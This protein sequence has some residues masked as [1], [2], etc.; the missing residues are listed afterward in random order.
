MIDLFFLGLKVFNDIY[1]KYIGFFIICATGIYF[2]IK[3]K[4]YQ[5]KTLFSLKKNLKELAEENNNDSEGVS[6]FKLYFASVGGMVGLGNI[7]SV[8]TAVLVGGPGSILWMWVASLCGMLLKYSETFLG[9][10]Y[11]VYNTKLMRYDGGPMYYLPHAFK[12]KML[13]FI[14]AFLM[15][16]YGVEVY[17]FLVLTDRIESTFNIDRNLIVVSLI[18]ITL[19][20]V[21][22]GILRLSNICSVMMPIFMV[23]YLLAGIGIILLHYAEL[24]ALFKLIFK[25]AFIGHAPIGGFLGSTMLLA[26]YR[27]T[28]GAVYSGDI[29]IGYD[30]IV[31]S[32]TKV[33]SPKKQA[34]LAIYALFTDT[35]ICSISTM[36]LLVSNSWYTHNDV[37]HSDIIAKVLGEYIPYIE[38][39]MTVLLFFAGYTT[40]I[41]Y[42]VAG[43]KS[44]YFLNQK[45]GRSIYIIYAI[46]SFIFFSKFSQEKVGLM[47]SAAAGLLVLINI[48]AIIRLR[49]NIEF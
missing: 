26:A 12:S 15:C 18:V 4:G 24:P 41:A 37:Q 14:F 43:L 21:S 28:S 49:K 11:R 29:C 47:M 30:A 45:N 33:K 32:E 6:P 42:L 9:I 17:Q 1:W 34:K 3:S 36:L 5:F 19:Y 13:P 20:T 27:G 40:I 44:A 46:C 7:V 23:V 10:K 22:G 38:Y 25:S 35:F 31:Q 16:I 39:F 2:T 8:T 48:T